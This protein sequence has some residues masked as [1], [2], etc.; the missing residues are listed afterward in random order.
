[1]NIRRSRPEDG[2]RL[3]ELWRAAVDAT[4]HFL[5]PQDRRAIDEEV[6]SFLPQMPLWLAVDERDLAIAFLGLADSAIEALFVHSD[7]HG[8]GVGRSLVD[9]PLQLH[10]I[11]TTDVNE[12]NGLALGFYERLGFVRT[13]R[14]A[15]DDQGR[16]YPLINLRID[17]TTFMR[18]VR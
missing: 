11:L 8:V 12:Q 10:P 16:R 3:I 14:S 6:Q 9:H 13:G 2:R 18:R 7:Y 15:V 17:A 5:A 1:M 4:H